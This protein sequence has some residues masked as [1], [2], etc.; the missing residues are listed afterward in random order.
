MTTV[1][2]I[3]LTLMFH[4]RQNMIM[5]IVERTTAVPCNKAQG[6]PVPTSKYTKFMKHM[7]IQI[8]FDSSNSKH[9]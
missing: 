3:N 7:Y 8:E 6:S 5:C 2:F 4:T 1:S 9:T